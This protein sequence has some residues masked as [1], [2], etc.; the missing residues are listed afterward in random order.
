MA[1]Q[2]YP[3]HYGGAKW[4]SLP[5]EGVCA[6][7]SCIPTGADDC[8]YTSEWAGDISV[9]ELEG[10]YDYEEFTSS[11]NL[12][13]S[14]GEDKGRGNGFWDEKFDDDKCQQRIQAANALFR[15]K[16]PD[17]PD[18]YELPGPDCDFHCTRFY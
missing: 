7:S 6:C 12:E 16:Y 4:Y 8:T 3:V 1:S 15:S 17:A 11:G 14:Q 10:I 13:Y 18:D 2:G 9:S 5:G